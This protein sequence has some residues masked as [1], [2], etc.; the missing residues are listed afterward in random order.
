M[1]IVG[2]ILVYKP[3]ENK[4]DSAFCLVGGMDDPTP[5]LL[6]AQGV[7]PAKTRASRKDLLEGYEA[8]LSKR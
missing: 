4:I 2:R 7:Q 3:A 1:F 5:M 6:L 8:K